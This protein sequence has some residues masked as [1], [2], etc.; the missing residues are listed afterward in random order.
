MLSEDAPGSGGIP[1]AAT[2]VIDR[3]YAWACPHLTVAA[4]VLVAL[5]S[6]SMLAA[7]TVGIREPLGPDLTAR[8]GVMMPQTAF[9][10]ALAAVSL[11]IWS[12]AWRRPADWVGSTLAA[13]AGLLGAGVITEAV[14]GV[15]L[16]IDGR[17]FALLYLSEPTARPSVSVATNLVML[18][19]ALL[20]LR[21]ESPRALRAA[22]VLAA[23]SI[24]WAMVAGLGY[25]F[26]LQHVRD[27]DTLLDGMRVIAPMSLPSATCVLLLG[28][29]VVFARRENTLAGIFERQDFGGFLARRLIPAVVI[30]PVVIGWLNLVATRSGVYS[31][32]FGAAVPV[33]AMVGSLVILTLAS[34]AALGRLDRERLEAVAT[35]ERRERLSRTVFEKAS[36]GIALV[37]EDGRPVTVN[38]AL[39]RMLGYD[40][41]E[42]VGMK[43]GQF[44]HP[45][46]VATDVTLFHELM[47]GQ[48]DSYEIEKRFLRRDGSVLW[49]RL[50]AAAA[51]DDAGQLLYTVGLVHDITE[52]K[53][54]EEARR[55]LTAILET[56]P[57]FVGMAD[58]TGH[59]LYVN[60][61]GRELIGASEDEV[62]RLSIPDFH[63][64]ESAARVLAEGL[65]TALRAG[66]WRGETELRGANGTTIPVSQVILSHRGPDGSLDF[67]STVMR[68]ISERK[69]EEEE[70]KVLLD[71]SRAFSTSLEPDATLHA[72]TT[73]V[74]PRIADFC[75]VHL[76]RREGQLERAASK[77]A[78]EELQGVLDRLDRL[79]PVAGGGLGI[80][81]TVAGGKPQLVSEVLP[82]WLAAATTSRSDR[83]V[84]EEL[85]PR[86]IMIVPLIVGERV[87]GAM[88][89]ATTA[90]ARR[91][92][93][94]DLRLAENLAHRAA[95]ALENARLFLE[96]REATRVRDEV[97]RVVAHDLRNPLNTISLTADLLH[98]RLGPVAGE[99]VGR[100]GL[101]RRSID[102][103]NH[104]IEDLLDVARMEAGRLTIEPTRLDATGLVREVAEL[105]H[106][107]AA[108]RAI[109]LEL[110]APERSNAIHADRARILQVFGNLVANAIRFSPEGGRVR[111][112]A[113]RDAGMVRFSVADEGPGIAPESISHL[114][115]PFWQAART[116]TGGAGLGLSIARGIV[117]AH[118]GRIWVESEPGHGSTFHFT[119]PLDRANAA[120]GGAAA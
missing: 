120:A 64:P 2:G 47:T 89:L 20:L 10:L 81:Q 31:P 109:R 52:G 119:V 45:D 35:M 93:A 21:A 4:A 41:D 97:L 66:V 46:D 95:L 40:A 22:N 53:K 99:E 16:D 107:L 82:A 69:E 106:A 42:I 85:A 103:A 110:D 38:P 60:R 3:I 118:G 43:F 115:D 6:V 39:Q 33:G 101:I 9:G 79:A 108:A 32:E 111:V 7:W 74:V 98:E 116:G 94:R 54:A 24:A 91:Y 80:A 62:A 48:R 12:V 59:A 8:L 88:M 25:G 1:I 73:V 70:Q 104:L 14:S 100:L 68:D 29:G 86:S 51:R 77:H 27:P 18:A 49:G 36:V 78:H 44:T 19:V 96:S 90:S 84:F 105:H 58:E 117:E 56:T 114:F 83:S 17:L 57:D 13:L 15:N 92:H 30:I 55:R 28:V 102:Q 113:R 34:A 72:L 23:G 61:A 50:N 26:G 63:P 5:I 11:W 37:D 71:A 112:S 75:T 87:L 67:V 65:P 76:V